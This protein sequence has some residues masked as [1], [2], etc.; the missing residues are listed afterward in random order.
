MRLTKRPPSWLHSCAAPRL[1]PTRRCRRRA[2]G[3]CWRSLRSSR[4]QGG[5]PWS[6][7]EGKRA[8]LLLT[9]G[10]GLTAS[11]TSTLR[12]ATLQTLQVLE[13]EI[14]VAAEEGRGA[15]CLE[16]AKRAAALHEAM[17]GTE[18]SEQWLAVQLAV[19]K[20]ALL[21]GSEADTKAALAEARRCACQPPWGP[22]SLQELRRCME[23]YGVPG[24]AAWRLMREVEAEAA[25]AAKGGELPGS[26]SEKKEASGGAGKG[27]QA[28]GA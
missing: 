7:R 20:V 4:C 6:R 2:A 18:M 21:F 8:P 12:Y 24:A 1:A 10:R 3:R 17:F 11:S 22:L 13:L 14:G 15:D 16:A 5:D 19:C 27:K 9:G 25:A 23:A 28:R 26:S